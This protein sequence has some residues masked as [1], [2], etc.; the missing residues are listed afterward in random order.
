MFCSHG[1]Y[2]VH[3]SG[4]PL[5]PYAAISSLTGSK[6]DV[7]TRV[8]DWAPRCPL[9]V[10]I[11]GRPHSK[12]RRAYGRQIPRITTEWEL[13]NLDKHILDIV[14]QVAPVVF[15]NRRRAWQVLIVRLI[16]RL[17]VIFEARRGHKHQTQSK[18]ILD[19]ICSVSYKFLSAAWRNRPRAS[20]A[21]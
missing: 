14:T 15:V 19:K 3:W 7:F 2:H 12:A 13:E 17:N 6:H 16:F 9:T 21:A 10:R 20:F 8:F 18:I 4:V 5:I 11:N 1:C